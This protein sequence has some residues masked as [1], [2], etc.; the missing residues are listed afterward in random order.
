MTR[1]RI[2]LIGFGSIAGDLAAALLSRR[3]PGFEIGV[4]LR[5]DSPSRARVTAA[6]TILSDQEGLRAFAPDLVVEAAGH[7][8]VRNSV[9]AC[10]VD[11][12][13][14]LISSIGALHDAS[15]QAELV[16]A[17]RRGRSRLLLASGALGA[18]D[19]VRAVRRATELKL[20]YQSRKPPAAWA[21]ELEALGHDPS[22]LKEPLALFSGNARDAAG[23][24]PQNLNVAAA[25]ALAGPGFEATD[26]AVICDPAA[27]GNTHVVEA[28]SE[29][30]T[31]KLTI[32]NRPSPNNPK[33]SW[34]VG[35]SLLA[36][37]DQHFAP[38]MM[39]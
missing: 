7:E 2:V 29:F 38:I 22:A 36:A 13:P 6:V 34:I 27:T 12:F 23:A 25:L 33:S 32:V 3:D 8:A 26:V 31:M 30:G 35:Q 9:P 15:L 14:V 4:L 21:K 24:Y 20:G 16:A 10:L 37:I 39:L 17:A 28:E 1:H 5:P 19:Y 18:L 11:G